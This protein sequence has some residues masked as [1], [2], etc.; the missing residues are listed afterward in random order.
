MT[1]TN[2]LKNL[3]LPKNGFTQ[4]DVFTELHKERI[5]WE[6]SQVTKEEFSQNV[7]GLESC[8]SRIIAIGLELE[9][10]VG[11][12]I[13][14]A[15]EKVE[16]IPPTAIKGM[17]ANI[18]DEQKHEVVFKN[19]SFAYGVNPQDSYTAK[20]FRKRIIQYKFNPIA[21]T[22][23]LESIIFL[24]V[25]GFLRV[26]G[27]QNLERVVADISHDELRHTNFGW[28]LSTLL[29]IHRNKEFENL[30]T[31]A[32]NWC[33]NPLPRQLFAVWI[34]MAEEIKEQGYSDNLHQMLNYGIHRAP[35]EISNAAY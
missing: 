13:R 15:L 11:S 9:L 26:Y 1:Q 4:E 23:D 18:E 25:Q 7:E 33:F 6:P 22:R 17:V 20:E 19:L 32:V 5:D 12:F 29:R 16:D 3:D 8:F 34:D 24:I 30:C 28:E 35:F 31:Q 2:L 21:K 14:A 10:P 27:G